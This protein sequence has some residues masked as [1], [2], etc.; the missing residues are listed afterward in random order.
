MK[1]A[2]YTRYST[3]RQRETSLDDQVR[4]CKARAESIGLIPDYLIY[5]DDGVS[6]STPIGRR[7]HGAR[8]L[9]DILAGRISHL[10]IEGLDRLSRDMVE[11]ERFVRR[12]EH[13]GIRLIGVADG[14][15]SDAAS[16]KINRTMRGLMNEMYID[17]LRHKTHR[18]LTGQ[19]ER[20]GHAGGV[21]YGYR[22]VPADGVHK[23]EII[24]E[25]ARVVRRIFQAYAAGASCQRIAA[26][27]NADAIPT[28][29][30]GTWSVSALYGSPAKGSGVLNNELYIGTLVWNRSQWVKDP[31]TGKRTR[32]D[33]P[34]S[35]WI[36]EQ[37]PELR[38]IDQPLW[39]AVRARFG[40]PT[41]EGGGTGKGKRPTTLFGGLIRCAKC[42]GVII[43]V[44]GRHYGCAQRK[45]RG[46]AVC[47]GVMAKR[48]VVDSRLIADIRSQVAGAD[49]L[50]EIQTIVRD[51]IAAKART[52]EPEIR[53]LQ[54][55]ATGIDEQ[56]ARIIDA[57]ANVGHSA[58][59]AERLAL[60][61][62]RRHD[63]DDD[64]AKLGAL[65][66][67]DTSTIASRFRRLAFELEH[68]LK[69]NIDQARELLRPFVT[70]AAMAQRGQNVVVEMETGRAAIA[71]GLSLHMVA[72]ARFVTKRQILVG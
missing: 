55:E 31:E 65:A 71:V 4:V 30:G 20:G 3:D 28:A 59:L 17:D 58:A 25:Q 70:G 44:S 35:E 64:I 52:A 26:D 9:A 18:G 63:I 72:G 8:L 66:K 50:A 19:I 48:D 16:R 61:E 56:I 34:R 32:L 68:A 39:N 60:L 69:A 7:P 6:G 49:A 42:G 29:R 10:I 54:A 33:R 45:D 62:H 37:H 57:I 11:Q 24:P 23:L 2:I 5:G 27:L 13:R 43:A 1:T 36:T 15:D 41:G 14:Y 21:P 38:I 40:R 46:E 22:S 53:R 12:L 47:T 51:I 67:I